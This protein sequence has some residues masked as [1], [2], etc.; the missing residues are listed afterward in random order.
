MSPLRDRPF[1]PGALQ[2]GA[3]RPGGL[4][5]AG[6]R[7]SGLLLAASLAL[8]AAP[9]VPLLGSLPALA[10]DAEVLVDGARIDAELRSEYLV[11]EQVRVP[12]T[13]ANPGAAPVRFADL[14][15][16]PW[17][18][19]FEF[20][21]ADGTKLRRSTAAP[22][23]DDG[24][25]VQIPVRGQRRTL[26]EAPGAEATAPGEYQLAVQLVRGD[27]VTDIRRQTVRFSTPK[28]AAVDLGPDAIAGSKVG[29]QSAWVHRATQ[30]ADLYLHQARGDDPT[31]G[32]ASRHLAHLDAVVQP[33]LAAA[34]AADAQSPVVAWAAGPRSLRV[35]Q[36]D[37]TGVV[38]TDRTVGLPW[39][40]AEI[41]GRPGL[42][43]G[44]VV[45][46]PLWIADPDG[47][48]GELR[49][50][51]LGPG[52]KLGF[53]AV[54]RFDQRPASLR[55]MVDASGAVQL[56]ISHA[57][58]LDLYT[59]RGSTAVGAEALPLAGRRLVAAQ[60]GSSILSARF[61]VV[62]QSDAHAGGVAVFAVVQDATGVAGQW[63]DLRGNRIAAT[64]PVALPAGATVAGAH[65]TPAGNLALLLRNGA[66]LSWM[67][68]ARRL[69]L[70]NVSDPVDVITDAQGRAVLRASSGV[71]PVTTRSLAP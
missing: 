6:L 48:G 42:A 53:A 66:A 28:V 23:Q 69:P 2:P 26:L 14:S 70:G 49:V 60:A 50:A 41:A 38:A 62:P 31:A 21:G 1:H 68:G 8:M 10:D 34:R 39:P 67:D 13:V 47:Q 45:G 20:T 63:L 58:G 55:T 43:A 64:A 52:D 40:A 24:R 29:V 19:R 7:L 9:L 46:V 57:G 30:G 71:A 3:I 44:G 27:Q 36:V 56:L 33:W 12:I 61:G 25:T 16:R 4:R 65:V 37:Q 54:S 18:V 35:L 51:T 15:A 5:P 59:L 11:G 17:L 22:A 32:G